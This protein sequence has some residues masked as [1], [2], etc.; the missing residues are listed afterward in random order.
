MSNEE[1]SERQGVSAMTGVFEPVHAVDDYYDG[2][3]AGVAS[4]Q[5]RHYRFRSVGWTS[6]DGPDGHWD[7]CDDRF[8][9]IPIE[10]DGREALVVRGEFRVRQ[11]APDLHP[12]IVRPLEVRWSPV[13]DATDA[14][15]RAEEDPADIPA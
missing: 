8:E 11:P 12:G 5:D 1:D 3:R 15:Q 7:P 10:G 2:P 4:Y 13:V 9:L 6:P 14:Q